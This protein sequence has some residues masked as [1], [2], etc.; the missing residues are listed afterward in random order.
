MISIS[1]LIK[2]MTKSDI[3]GVLRKNPYFLILFLQ[4]DTLTLTLT[5]ALHIAH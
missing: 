1:D 5:L 2:V 3:N 4:F